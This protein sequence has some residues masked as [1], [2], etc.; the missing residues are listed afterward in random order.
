MRDH[1][2]D[3]YR[4]IRD[5]FAVHVLRWFDDFPG[6]C[7][8]KKALE[9]AG[10]RWPNMAGNSPESRLIDKHIM[11]AWEE[12]RCLPRHKMELNRRD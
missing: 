9:A 1:T 5:A 3:D 11:R 7:E 8:A 6:M 10:I 12:L 2:E 4:V